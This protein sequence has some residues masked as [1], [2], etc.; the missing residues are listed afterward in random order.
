MGIS[1][2]GT[3]AAMCN[4]RVAAVGAGNGFSTKGPRPSFSLSPPRP[5]PEADASSSHTLLP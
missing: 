5:A 3:C 2:C 1:E 4:A